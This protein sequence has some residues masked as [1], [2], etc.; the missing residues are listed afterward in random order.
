MRSWRPL[1]PDAADR[2]NVARQRSEERAAQDGADHEREPRSAHAAHVGHHIRGPA[3]EPGPI[4]EGAGVLHRD[5]RLEEQAAQGADRRP[6]R[7]DQNGERQRGTAPGAHRSGP[8]RRAGPGRIGREE[9]IDGHRVPGADAGA[10]GP[11]LRRRAENVALL[12]QPHLE[13]D[14]L[15]KAPGPTS[16]SAARTGRR[17]SRSRT[18]RN[19][20]SATTSTN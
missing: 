10:S 3:E 7:S 14:P 2:R 17:R 12:R 16:R 11:R 19:T 15:S 5:P 9:R 18:S 1:E 20:S 8:A 4:G 13:H 6:V